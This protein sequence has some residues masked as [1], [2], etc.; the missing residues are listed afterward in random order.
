MVIDNIRRIHSAD[1][2]EPFTLLLFD[3]RAYFVDRRYYLAISPT[4]KTVTYAPQT[5]GFIDVSVDRIADA[6]P[7]KPANRREAS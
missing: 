2:F 6:I 1:P 5:G 3:G 4:G 7:G